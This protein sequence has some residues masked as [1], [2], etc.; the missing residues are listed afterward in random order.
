M[1]KSQLLFILLLAFIV[2][3]SLGS[4][5]DFK[6]F[7]IQAALIVVLA[8]LGVFWRRNWKVVFC[9]AAVIFLLLGLLRISSFRPTHTFLTRFA[10]TN[11]E[12]TLFGYVDSLP[13]QKNTSQQ[14]VFKVRRLEVPQYRIPEDLDERI[15]VI[16][17]PYP[18]YHY[19]DKLKLEGKIKLPKNYQ[20]FDYISYLAK[21]QIHTLTFKPKA[22]PIEPNLKLGERLKISFLASIFS[23]KEKFEEK[24]SLS[25]VEPQTSLLNGILLGSRQNLPADIKEDFAR[26]GLSHVMAISGYNIT[27]LAVAVF[28]ILLWFFPRSI[29]FWLSLLIMIIFT[30]L[31]GASASVIRSALMGGLVL[32]AQQSGRLYNAKNALALV[33]FLMLWA[34]PMVLRYDI[35]FQLSFLATV[36]LLYVS[37][38]LQVY[39]KKLPGVFKLRETLTAT[40]AAQ[41]MTL[42]LLLYYFHNFSLVSVIANVIILPLI[43]FTMLLGFL[44]GLAGLV[45][46]KLGLLLGAAS[47]ILTSLIL[48]IVHGLASLPFGYFQIFISWP[49]MIILYLII[50]LGVSWLFRKKKRLEAN[51]LF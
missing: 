35:G 36:G 10:D 4:F 41:I 38:L 51:D 20:E 45:W 27:I 26:T 7:T 11:F 50:L 46:L 14:F 40:L 18:Q 47:W 5:F 3:V 2:G 43:P 19:G 29:V 30:V 34:N 1:H 6:L 24:L 49:G 22:S 12:T 21:D 48:K 39:F 13:E 16:T 28:W 37:P 25:L 44:T 33:A 23:L 8:V 17:D 9:S 42:P 15:L 31:T 32:L